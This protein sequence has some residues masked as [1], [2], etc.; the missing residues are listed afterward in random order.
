MGT[1]SV[2]V[3]HS[4]LWAADAVANVAG[5]GDGVTLAYD[6]VLTLRNP[7]ESFVIVSKT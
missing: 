3:G 7:F 6:G 4:V 5:D 2:T 1:H